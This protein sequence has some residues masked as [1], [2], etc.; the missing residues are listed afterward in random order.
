MTPSQARALA[1]KPVDAFDTPWR[2][3]KLTERFVRALNEDQETLVA[4]LVER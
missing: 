3:P 4:Q 2:L 1:W